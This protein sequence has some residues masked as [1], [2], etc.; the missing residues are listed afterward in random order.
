MMLNTRSISKVPPQVFVAATFLVML[1]VSWRKWTS[2][3]VDIGRETD[4]PFRLM[5]GEML[6]RDIHYLY[7]PF[8]PYFNSLLYRVFGVHLDT[9]AFS[10]IV[11]TAILVMLC[12]AIARK[13][14]PASGA[15]VAASLITVM[16]FKPA[17]SLILPYSFAGLHGAVFAFASVY[18]TMRFAEKRSKR[19]L[20]I[21]GIFIG[22]ATI[23]KQEFGFASAAA[24][25]AYAIFLNRSNLRGIVRDVS[26]AAVPALLI[27]VPVFGLL[28]ATVDW[29][30][31][32]DDCHL[33]FTNIPE[34]LEYYNR[35][36]SGLNDPLGS[37]V[38]MIGAAAISM[39]FAVLIIFLSDRTKKMRMT[40]VYWFAGSFVAALL[41]LY[42]YREGW[43][44]SPLRAVP[45]LLVVFI[46]MAWRQKGEETNL[47]PEISD[48]LA[49]PH[50]LFILAV[51]SLAILARVALRVPSGGFSGSFYVPAS[52]ILIVYALLRE[53]PA[54]I[55][56]WTLDDR[57]YLR[58]QTITFMFCILAV[59]G[60]VVSFSIRYSSRFGHELSAAR[61]NGGRRTRIGARDR[62]SDRVH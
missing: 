46:V 36:R 60:T 33:F 16:S 41:V 37:F 2:M 15:A 51:F 8:S 38:Q 9:L 48:G 12:Y 1:V 42:L 26:L 55:K 20:L 21:S 62:R 19:D 27:T 39:T 61:G 13:L 18:F 49:S 34:S 43:D 4:L 6:Y 29:R 11:F 57:S 23:T 56:K 54:G 30:I 5:N 45:F 28:F 32:I 24:V 47:F 31:L 59:V 35:F 58:A 22:L 10:G 14:M 50:A 52:L 25:T 44:G 17:G 53:L 40:L 3:I 7:P